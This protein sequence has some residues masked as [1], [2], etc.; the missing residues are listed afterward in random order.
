[1]ICIVAG[2]MDLLE[3]KGGLKSAAAPHVGSR[4]I[5]SN[6]KK[7]QPPNMYGVYYINRL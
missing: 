3:K 6:M 2:P 1:M 7:D 4:W 5:A